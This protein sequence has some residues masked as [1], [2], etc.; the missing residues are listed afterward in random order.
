MH[1]GSSPLQQ[2]PHESSQL[3]SHYGLRQKLVGPM[4]EA[5]LLERLTVVRREHG[6]GDPM[7]AQAL[8]GLPHA[9]IKAGNVHQR[10]PNRLGVRECAVEDLQA[11]R[12]TTRVVS[13]PSD[14]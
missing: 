4:A 13:D 11:E 6:K 8:A 5:R 3:A 9:G 7:A 12:F 14:P 10:Q 2:T 1:T